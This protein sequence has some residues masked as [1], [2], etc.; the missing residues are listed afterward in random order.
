[1]NWEEYLQ[2]LLQKENCLDNISINIEGQCIDLPPIV[3]ASL[4][5]HEKMIKNQG[6]RNIFVFPDAEQIP[7]LFV[8]SKVIFNISSGQVE[9]Q[10]SPEKFKPGQIMKIGNCVTQFLGVGEHQL[11][12]G[13]K[14]IFLKFADCDT[15]TCPLEM[16]PYFQISDTKKRLSKLS[17]YKKAKKDLEAESAGESRALQDLKALKTHIGESAAYVSTVADSER[18]AEEIRID[19]ETLFEYLLV[20]KADYL[21]DLHYYKGKYVGTPALIFSSHI[22]YINEVIAGKTKVQS[23]IINLNETDI[24]SQLDDLDSLLKKKISILCLSDT[25]N[26][27]DLRELTNRGFNVWRWDA[28][29]LSN[30]V[31]S[32]ADTSSEMKIR[33]CMDSNVIYHKLIAP[34][35]SEAFISVYKYNKHI[36]DDSVQVNQIYTKLIHLAY[37][38]VRGICDIAS[39]DRRR[40]IEQLEVCGNLLEIEK[41]YIDQELYK[42]FEKALNLFFK[43][44]E[45]N[46]TF[47]KTEEIYKILIE[48]KY[49]RFYIIC[50][51]NDNPI[52]VKK[53]WESRL[54]K[55]GYRPT[56]YVVYPKEFLGIDKTYADVAILSGW[57]SGNIVK[58]ILYGYKVRTIHVFTYECEEKWKKAHIKAW[59]I[60]LNNE[61][62]QNIIKKSFSDK[63]E[64]V[65]TTMVMRGRLDEEEGETLKLQDD[66]DIIMQE[67]RYR[68][69]AARGNSDGDQVVQAK[70]VGFVGGD[71]AL[72]TE[73]HK[74]LVATKIILQTS[75]QIEKKELDELKVGDFI[76]VRESD[77][78]IIRDVADRILEANQKA[79]YRKTASLWREA[80]KIEEAFSSVDDIYNRLMTAGCSRNYQTVKNWLQSDDLIIPQDADD[81]KYI[82]EITG[83]SVLV[84]KMD[85]II[86]AG[87]FVKNTHIKAGR[88]LSDRLRESIAS[89]L[90]KEKE[91]D[92]Y[93]IWEPI[94]IELDE[95][96]MVKILKIIDIGQEFI[97]VE[98]SNTNKVLAEEKESILWQG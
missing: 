23:V 98:A 50:S 89:I 10:Y 97:P 36:E 30:V 76:V 78:D 13:K 34:E 15:Y 44:F 77:K 39:D 9:N 67:S 55:S 70:P 58:R 18:R 8:L 57:F 85:E 12:P 22:S 28:D 5:L 96:G 66:F 65:S 31:C 74:V 59:K 53:Y 7:F 43:I 41:S 21:G 24:I 81:L 42:G 91:I 60:G 14:V 84:E 51:N 16:A 63:I 37:I 87:N 64:N 17:S 25:I 4:L 3:K 79:E 82:A 49:E 90:L 2:D 94:E 86:H 1:M 20:A 46:D 61:N 92:P 35:I 56:I 62:N 88:V 52:Y 45:R 75:S 83:D 11:M 33:R 6:K 69:Y 47:P 48:N 54:A 32:G 29:S 73:G 93:N 26:S 38:S 80:L 95:V 68:Q 27:I 71:F 72:F 40:I 19:G